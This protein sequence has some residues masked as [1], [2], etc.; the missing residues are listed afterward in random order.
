MFEGC[1]K[2]CHWTSA[3]YID[4]NCPC[5]LCSS[6]TP[7]V[8]VVQCSSCTSSVVVVRCMFEGCIKSCHWTSASYI[9]LN[10]PLSQCVSLQW[11]IRDSCVVNL[12]C[13]LLVE[14]DVILLRPGQ[15]V[16]VRCRQLKVCFTYLHLFHFALIVHHNALFIMPTFNVDYLYLLTKIFFLY[17][18]LVH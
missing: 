3:S 18:L 12:P 15:I 17:I 11:T 7:S 1:I 5:P 8:V 2:S 13:T 16:C 10:C 6:F 9:D 14:G 4:L